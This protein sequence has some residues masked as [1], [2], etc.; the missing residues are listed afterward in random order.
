MAVIK[1]K[2]VNTKEAVDKELEGF[3]NGPAPTEKGIYPCYVKSLEMKTNK[4]KDPMISGMA[5]VDAPKGHKYFKFNGYAI[6]FQQNVTDQGMAYVNQFL[7]ALSDGTKEHARKIRAGFWEG[8]LVTE[9]PLPDK[10]SDTAG[11]IIK[12]G[13]L[14]LKNLEDKTLPILIMGKPVTKDDEPKLEA[15]RYMMKK[16]EAP[17][18]E[19]EYDEDEYEEGEEDEDEN[20]EEVDEDPSEDDEADTEEDDPEDE[21]EDSEY[22][23]EDEEDEEDEDEDEEEAEPVVVTP[24]K[25]K[26][27]REPAF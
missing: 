16:V 11:A 14:R 25:K 24:I 6:F 23:D 19:Y 26:A 22:E 15:G 13:S 7:D 9:K 8:G 3:Y 21:D 27:R 2:N 5:I 12:I 4:N 20:E 1:F 18:E 17:E 10:A